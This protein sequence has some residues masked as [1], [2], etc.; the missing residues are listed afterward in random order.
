MGSHGEREKEREEEGKETRKRER[1]TEQEK[2]RK[3]EEINL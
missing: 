3:V 2:I 1:M